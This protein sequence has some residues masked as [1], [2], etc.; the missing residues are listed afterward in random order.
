[1]ELNW[2]TF[3]LEIINF[4]V[5]LWLLKYFFYQPVLKVIAD[6]QTDIQ[7]QLTDA[8]MKETEAKAL[9]AQYENR[10]QEWE[11][12]KQQERQLL[13]GEI[14][15]ERARLLEEVH[16]SIGEERQKSQAQEQR[17]LQ[18]L[19]QQT[20]RKAFDYA[21]SFAARLLS[22]FSSPELETRIAHI[23]VED[24]AALPEKRVDTIRAA[25]IQLDKPVEICS[26]Y[27]LSESVKQNLETGLVKLLAQQPTFVFQQSSSLISGIRIAA[28]SWLFE[29]SIENELKNFSRQSHHDS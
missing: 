3:L 28:G 7:R 14:S 4:L 26:A 1:M 27:P 18:E 24:M 9:E 8:A 29:A 5:L 22:R 13:Q 11:H 25:C 2:S 15:H 16:Q 20:E 12:E 19:S 21:A 17:H 10:L 6:R 23:V